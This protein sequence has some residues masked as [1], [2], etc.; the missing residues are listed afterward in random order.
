MTVCGFP[1]Q[2]ACASGGKNSHHNGNRKRRTSQMDAAS[3]IT[4]Q[5][6]IDTPMGSHEVGA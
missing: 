4:N 3:P 5:R 2:I 1:F 6:L